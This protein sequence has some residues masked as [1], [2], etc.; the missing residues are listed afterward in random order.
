MAV[1]RVR[2]S[3]AGAFRIRL[4]G[5]IDGPR[6]ARVEIAASRRIGWGF[7]LSLAPLI[8]VNYLVKKHGELNIV[9]TGR[10]VDVSG[11]KAM[12]GHGYELIEGVL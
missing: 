6:A 12:L 8:L 4:P 3:D 2:R 11:I 5:D 10:P 7:S 9:E 1:D